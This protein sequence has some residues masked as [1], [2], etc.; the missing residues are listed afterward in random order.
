MGPLPR[1]LLFMARKCK[2]WQSHALEPTPAPTPTPR[3]EHRRAFNFRFHC[4]SAYN[5]ILVN[6]SK[7]GLSM[8]WPWWPACKSLSEWVRVRFSLD[9]RFT[10]S[11]RSNG[12]R[13]RPPRSPAA[14]VAT[15]LTPLRV[16]LAKGKA[17]SQPIYRPRS[18]LSEW[19]I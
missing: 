13:L 1:L 18:G 2:R 10:I 3:P 7:T 6:N 11:M 8:W 19:L 16:I 12:S 14:V 15:T 17:R 4:E 9:L 5:L